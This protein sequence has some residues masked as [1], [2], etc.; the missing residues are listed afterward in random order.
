MD[1]GQLKEIASILKDLGVTG[2][3][4]I[5]MV[6]YFKDRRDEREHSC[7]LHKHTSLS[8]HSESSK[9]GRAY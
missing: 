6:F 4:A 5:A 2:L 1:L 9:N 8:E 3:F 7:S